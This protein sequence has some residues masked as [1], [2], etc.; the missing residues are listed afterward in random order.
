MQWADARRSARSAV[1]MLDGWPGVARD[2]SIRL[3]RQLGGRPTSGPGASPLSAREREVAALIAQG[4]TN[5]QIAASLC[6]S[7]RT[8]GVHVQNILI[9]LHAAN[10]AEVAAQVVRGNLAG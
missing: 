2:H 1:D 6:I 9:K 10:R 4:L 5:P 8:V 7:P 3:L